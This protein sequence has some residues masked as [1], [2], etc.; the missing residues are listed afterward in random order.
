MCAHP[1]NA[2]LYDCIYALQCFTLPLSEEGI[3]IENE[4]IGL[5]LYFPCI[6]KDKKSE[7]GEVKWIYL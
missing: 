3:V 5:Q 1:F 6:A 2:L 7:I 4:S